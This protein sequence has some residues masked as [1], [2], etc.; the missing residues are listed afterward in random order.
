[1]AEKAIWDVPRTEE[2]LQRLLT[3]LSEARA[4]RDEATEGRILLALAFIVKWVRSDN[5]ESPFERSHTL[6]LQALEIFRRLG[7]ASGQIS[8]LL[9]A[10]PFEPR[11]SSAAMLAQA[12]Q[13]AAESGNDFEIARV[14]SA[15]ARQ[16]GLVDRAQAK[17]L[18]KEALAIF[19]AL[20]NAGGAAGCL[21]SLSIADGT[22]AENREYALEAAKLYREA[23]NRNEAGHAVMIALMNA[24]EPGEVV[25]LEPHIK[26]ALEDAQTTGDRHTEGQC[27]GYLA[28]VAEAKGDAEEAAKYLRWKGDLKDSDGLSPLERWRENMA[29]SKT[30]IAMAKRMG[31]KDM[32][33]MF[34]DELRR[35]KRN[36][37]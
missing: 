16:M 11:D 32:G 6:A 18:T 28:Q 31:N 13:L 27:Y 22:P 10:A 33:R 3:L 9:S 25:S 23:G 34:Q 2:G 37:P 30:M 17:L 35:L 12:Q 26:E 29:M 24:K 36:K 20:G 7:D 14:L 1:M 8:A 15:R 21:F 4:A 5:D 19:R